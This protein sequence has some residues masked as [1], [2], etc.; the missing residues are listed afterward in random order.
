MSLYDHAPHP[1]TVLPDPAW[2][3][4]VRVGETIW[5]WH[6]WESMRL[7]S[8]PYRVT[9]IDR[10]RGRVH[11]E[12]LDPADPLNRPTMAFYLGTGHEFPGYTYQGYRLDP[13]LR[14]AA[15]DAWLQAQQA[16]EGRCHDREVYH[17][18]ALT[19]DA[20]GEGAPW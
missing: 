7:P 2:N 8:V 6:A 19:R 1:H 3:R 16:F 15:R 14:R 12:C 20:F 11:A 10:E 5:A 17:L 4:R 18:A 13:K 9:A